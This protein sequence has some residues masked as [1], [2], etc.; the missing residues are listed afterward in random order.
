MAGV[1]TMLFRLWPAAHGPVSRSLAA[2]SL[3]RARYSTS[4]G[5]ARKLSRPGETTRVLVVQPHFKRRKKVDL[6]PGETQFR[7]RK[8]AAR[9][10]E[11]Q[12]QEARGLAEAIPGWSVVSSLLAP[13][14]SVKHKTFLPQQHVEA[15]VQV[16]RNVSRAHKKVCSGPILTAAYPISV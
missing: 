8:L 9:S 5:H 16:L 10:P 14:S 1:D 13:G 7:Y 12:E 2:G 6:A 15:L 3:S 4:L 11:H